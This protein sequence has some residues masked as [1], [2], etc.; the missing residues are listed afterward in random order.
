M[1]IILLDG[2]VIAIV[3]LS[4]LLAMFR[5][6]VREILS[7]AAWVVAGV[8]AILLFEEL[9]PTVQAYVSNELIATA[10]AAFSIFLVTLIVVSLITMKI[11]DYV[12]DSRVGFIDR[13]LGFAFGAARGILLMVIA[14]VFFNWLVPESK[15]A[16]V[17]NARVYPIL[18]GLGEELVAALPENPDETFRDAQ[19][20]FEQR[21]NASPIGGTSNA[22]TGD[23][24]TID[25]GSRQG[26]EA[27]IQSTDEDATSGGG[28]G[29]GRE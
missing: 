23:G 5:G 1:N 18:S 19:R 25:E 24:A 6:F 22:E 27:L 10:I 17:A 11:S 20:R 4:A 15:P 7:I 28:A 29:A 16:F 9:T 13:T 8:A 26:L 12:I 14:V 21:I 2:I 3:L